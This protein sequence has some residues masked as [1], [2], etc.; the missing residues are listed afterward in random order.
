MKL[1]TF[2]LF[3]CI[4]QV[5]AGTYAQKITLSVKNEEL[6][7]VFDKISDQSGYDFI[8]I[9]SLLKDAHKVNINV[10]DA[11]LKEVLDQIFKDQPLEFSINNKTVLIKKKESS[12]I[13]QLIQRFQEIKVSGKVLDEHNL[14]LPGA[15]VKVKGTKKQVLT[16]SEGAFSLSHI[17]ENAILV[18]SFLGY[19]NKEVAAQ[20]N[21]GNIV[22]TEQTGQ[23]EEVTV[24]TGYQTL[25]KE[26]VTGAFSSIPAKQLEQQR[27]SSLDALLEGR[28]AGYN[29]GLIRGTTSMKGVTS[30]LYVVDGFP[31]E[32]TKYNTTGSITENLPGLNLEDIESIT[33]LKDAAAASIYGARA[34]N[35]V[36]VIVTKKPKKGKPQISASSTFTLS[37]GALYTDNLTNSADIIDLEREWERNNPKLKATNSADYAANVLT[38]VGYQSQGIKAIL[39]KY[40]GTL[41]Q[42]QLEGKLNQL[43]SSGYQYYDDVEKYSKRDPFYQ[44]Y[45]ISAGSASESNSFYSS[46]TYRNNKSADKYTKDESLGLNIHNTTKIN[47]WLT[48]ELSN[49]LSYNTGSQQNYNTLSPQYTFLPYDRLM[50]ADGTYFN[51]T[52]ASRLS[53]NTMAI[54]NS[55]GLYNVD[56][57]PLDE[58][59]K[60]LGQ[61][62]NFSNRSFIKLNADLTSWLSYRSTFQYEFG[63]DRFNRLYDKS[64]YY[65][66]NMVNSFATK[67]ANGPVTFNLPYGNINYD[68]DQFTSSYNFRQQVNIDKTFGDK[69]NLTAIVGTEIRNAKLEFKDQYLYNYDPNVLTFDLINA[70]SLGLLQGPILGG[71]N[72]SSSNIASQRENINRFVSIYANAGY[73]YNSKYLLTGSLR[74]DRSNLWGSNSKYQN[75]PLWSVGAGWNIYKESFFNVD[76]VDLLKLRISHGIAGNIAKDVAPYMTAYYS[77]NNNVGGL[78]G[79]IRARPNPLLSW[80]KTTTNNVGLDFAIFKNRINGSLDYYDKQGKDLLAST[81]GVPTEGFGYST[82]AINNGEMTNKGIELS[83]SGDVIRSKDLTWNT[84]I[85]YAHNKNKVTYVNVEAP[86]YYLQLDYPQAY[87]R[88]GN[89]YNAI[90]SYRWAGLNADGLPQV[91]NEKGEKVLNSP[92]TLGSIVYS[93]STVPTYSGAFN[94]LFEYKNFSLSFLFSF[95]GGHK[96]RNTFLPVL[97]SAYN[98]ALQGYVTQI[99]PV[100]KDITDRWR[101]AG[102]ENRTDIPRLVFGEDPAYNSQSAEIYQKAD[103]NVIDASNIRLRNLSLAYRLPKTLVK[104]AYMENVRFQFNVE[105]AFT[106]AKSKAA[107]YLLNGYR[108]ANFVWGVYVNF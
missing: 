68:Q 62:K 108:P 24:S 82:Y 22:L 61:S 91:Y 49:Y 84:S 83:I 79:T 93:G 97:G 42:T 87:P 69:H 102:D 21:I 43:A 46:L 63:S 32:N 76:W 58:Q 65:V 66:R 8:V 77:N 51:S 35:G 60:S 71:G 103:I 38:N 28:V 4:M 11:P 41:T 7:N 10:K 33:V 92:A 56:I 81:M 48:L 99:T 57:S 30:P 45:H 86:V 25:P 94:N 16:N 23:L 59:S 3:A 9:Y 39:A 40:A 29:N 107:K 34:A 78:Q 27:L 52:G 96:M 85:L 26:R 50:N 101:T 55:N 6:F 105:N 106:I 95:E 100:N 5:S 14:P 12:F 17:D 18:I 44:Q 72:F 15:T 67:V 1:T 54:I 13:D 80:E 74:W 2:L 88:I 64:T 104:K 36:I 53:A 89:P 73:A 19:Q 31:V 20:E 90:Y 37:S 98:A 70:K 75:K 47:K